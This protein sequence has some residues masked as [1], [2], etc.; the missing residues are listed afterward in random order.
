MDTAQLKT[1]I[2]EKLFEKQAGKGDALK[3][4]KALSGKAAA[5]LKALPGKAWAGVKAAPEMG[6]DTLI[7][8]EKLAKNVLPTGGQM[9]TGL[10]KAKEGAGNILKGIPGSSNVGHAWDQAK[11]PLHNK[12]RPHLPAR[13]SDLQHMRDWR[14]LK[15][16]PGVLKSMAPAERQAAADASWQGMKGLGKTTLGIGGLL[17][18]GYVGQDALMG[19]AGMGAGMIGDTASSLGQGFG[20]LKEVGSLNPGAAWEGFKDA[21]GSAQDAVN[22]V[23]GAGPGF[24]GLAGGALGAGYGS[25]LGPKGA[26]AAGLAGMAGGTLIGNTPRLWG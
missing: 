2:K 14:L 25:K 4:L 8:G 3:A 1:R 26:L 17:G 22:P 5:N 11:I 21:A 19:G 12:F 18:L 10:G 24:T 15:A 20:A 7:A 23:G 9:M 13:V 16:N 6:I